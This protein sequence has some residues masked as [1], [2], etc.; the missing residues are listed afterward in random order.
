[1][2]KWR[3]LRYGWN[4]TWFILDMC[5]KRENG[6]DWNRYKREKEGSEVQSNDFL[7][8]SPEQQ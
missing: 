6:D 2:H 4:L 7:K 8:W 5:E 1:M 3:L